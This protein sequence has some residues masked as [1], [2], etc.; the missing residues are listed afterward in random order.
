MA[1]N[2]PEETNT[3]N[4]TYYYLD[5]LINIKDLDFKHIVLDDKYKDSIIHYLRHTTPNHTKPI[6]FHE[7]RID[8]RLW[9]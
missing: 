6:T 5:D 1:D 8:Q 2:K 9:W 7:Q 3:K 4:Y